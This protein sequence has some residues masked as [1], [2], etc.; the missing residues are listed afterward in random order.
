MNIAFACVTVRWVQPN[1]AEFIVCGT[2]WQGAGW[3]A[4]G[5]EI[6]EILSTYSARET[7]CAATFTAD[8]WPQQIDPQLPA[9]RA[10]PRW[11]RCGA[12]GRL[13]AR[14]RTATAGMGSEAQ[15]YQA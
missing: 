9:C 12:N 8:S 5:C 11:Q 3:A 6:R 14:A 7:W 13:A 1:G 4:H 2:Q 15:A 10:K